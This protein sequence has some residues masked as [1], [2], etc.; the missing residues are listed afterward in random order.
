MSTSRYFES[1]VQPR[2]TRIYTRIPYLDNEIF[3]ND[4]ESLRESRKIMNRT[5]RASQGLARTLEKSM[6]L[7]SELARSRC[8]REKDESD[9]IGK[10]SVSKATTI[11][12]DNESWRDYLAKKSDSQ[13]RETR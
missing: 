13:M 11:T 4:V 12:R 6:L 1:R 3:N 8:Q 5:T 2:M 7:E 10:L 9:F